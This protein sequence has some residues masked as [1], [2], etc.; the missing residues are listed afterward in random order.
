MQLHRYSPNIAVFPYVLPYS[1]S[2][3]INWGSPR[4]VLI[5]S[6]FSHALNLATWCDRTGQPEGIPSCIRI[7]PPDTGVGEA[8]QQ[9]V[10]QVSVYFWESGTWN[11]CAPLSWFTTEES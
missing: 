7:Y 2:K 1:Y 10:K 3:G 4:Q 9:V 8:F 6:I 11:T 5:S